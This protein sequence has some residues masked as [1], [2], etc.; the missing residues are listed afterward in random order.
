MRTIDLDQCNMRASARR[1][2]HNGCRASRAS[3]PVALEPAGCG[4]I[5]PA[6]SFCRVG[7]ERSVAALG[8]LL[9]L[10]QALDHMHDVVHCRVVHFRLR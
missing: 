4:S 3:D 10:L 7:I 5:L 2:Q 6:E 8:G 1:G 9:L